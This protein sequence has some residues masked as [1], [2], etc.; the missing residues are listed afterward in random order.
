MQI[1]TRSDLAKLFS[2]LGLNVGVEVGVASGEFSEEILSQWNGYLYM[3]DCWEHQS[4]DVY[5]DISNHKPNVMEQVFAN[6]VKVTQKF[7]GRAGLVRKYSVQG[8]KFVSGLHEEIG[9]VYIDAN[10]AYDYVIQDLEAWYPLVKDGG[11]VAGH[12]YLDGLSHNTQF[13]VVSA[14]KDFTRDKNVKVN[15]IDEVW[16]S[17]WFIKNESEAR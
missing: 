6:A 13:G 2:H 17:W 12:D 8:A 5:Q 10:H 7:P 11:V 4:E 9:F 16:P 14:V 3:V 15:V 1:Q